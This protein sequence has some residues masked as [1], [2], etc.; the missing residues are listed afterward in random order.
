MYYIAVRKTSPLL[1]KPLSPLNRPLPITSHSLA[2]DATH[3]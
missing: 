2:L 3:A 1:C